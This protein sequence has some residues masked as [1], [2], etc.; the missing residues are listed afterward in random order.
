MR[1]PHRFISRQSGF[2]LLEVL[3]SLVVLSVGLL[4]IAGLETAGM[5]MTY[6]GSVWSAAAMSAQNI[7]DKMRAN[8]GCINNGATITSCTSTGG[9]IGGNY[10]ALT[11]K[12]TSS[13][14]CTTCTSA[15][16]AQVDAYDWY[17][18]I[19]NNLPSGTGSVMCVTASY[20]DQANYVSQAVYVITICWDDGVS[21]AP[22]AGC[23]STVSNG[24]VTYSS[25]KDSTYQV[26][27]LPALP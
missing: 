10:D 8:P 3:I 9:V 19:G 4:G 25:P 1:P 26:T 21:G 2:S 16:I 14:S 20:C 6:N 7:V 23:G 15:Q 17:T 13:P 11:A 27:V 18:T 24:A 22:A 12:P 5:R